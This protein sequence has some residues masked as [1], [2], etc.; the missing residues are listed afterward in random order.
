M[1]TGY[2]SAVFRLCLK[3]ST[4]WSRFLACFFVRPGFERFFP[5]SLFTWY[6]V[7]CLTITSYSAA[8]A[9]RARIWSSISKS[10]RIAWA[11]V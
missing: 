9:R 5:P 1:F 7:P 10:W 8:S 2:P 6:P 11:G 3:Y 4:C